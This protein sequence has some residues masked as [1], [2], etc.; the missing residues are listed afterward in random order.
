MGDPL[1]SPE[2]IDRIQRGRIARRAGRAARQAVRRATSASRKLPQFL[3]IGTQKG[4]TTSLHQYLGEHPNV[5]CPTTKEVHYFDFNAHRSLNWYRSHFPYLRNGQM[6][7]EATPYYLFHPLAP[8]RVAEALP[9]VKLVVLL[10][11]PIDR[12]YSH[13][14]H[15]VVLGFE[16]LSFSEAIAA[17]SSRLE[18]ETARLTTDPGY[19]SFAHQHHGYVS[20]GLY[21]DQ[22][23]AWR[24]C[25]KPE[26]ILIASSEDLFTR[27]AEVLGQVQDFLGLD[28][29]IPPHLHPHNARQYTGIDPKLRGE[30]SAH[31][32]PHNRRLYELVGRNFGWESPLP[33]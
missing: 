5:R 20:R 21:A 32:E 3:I 1:T 9:S 8:R 19:R 27:P 28:R 6:C 7:G 16:D 22:I 10:R 24:N 26:Q 31:F 17:E 11:N 15:E 4:G 29:Q 30:L 18:G 2:A 13:H 14:N 23:E 33:D 25:F 12:A